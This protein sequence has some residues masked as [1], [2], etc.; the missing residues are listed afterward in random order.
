M[1]KF[2]LVMIVCLASAIILGVVLGIFWANARNSESDFEDYEEVNENEVVKRLNVIE[3]LYKKEKEKTLEYNKKNRE[4]KGQLIKKMALLSTTS[5][6]LK[7]IQSKTPTLES[8]EVIEDLKNQLKMKN[9]EL[10]EFE[11]V[12][13]KAEETI[14]GFR[15]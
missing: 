1:E 4:L 2:I 14:E 8:Q 5:D 10:K 11:E 6:T 12:L 3:D 7:S 15:K 13:L 9:K